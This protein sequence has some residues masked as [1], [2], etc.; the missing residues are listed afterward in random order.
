M[1]GKLKLELSR[2]LCNQDDKSGQPSNKH[3]IVSIGIQEMIVFESK[4]MSPI[5]LISLLTK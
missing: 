1:F 3:R 5:I 2:S 4:V